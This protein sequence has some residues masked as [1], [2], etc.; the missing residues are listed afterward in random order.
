MRDLDTVPQYVTF[1]VVFEVRI[2]KPNPSN[3]VIDVTDSITLSVEECRLVVESSCYEKNLTIRKRF[4]NF[5]FTV[6]SMTA[7]EKSILVYT[8]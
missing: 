5:N 6:I 8:F 4:R 3:T 2:L 1:H 7:V